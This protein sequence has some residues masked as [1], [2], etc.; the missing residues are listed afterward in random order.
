MKG[1]RFRL[2][3]EFSQECPETLERGM[4]GSA[5]RQIAAHPLKPDTRGL[6]MFGRRFQHVQAISNGSFDDMIDLVQNTSRYKSAAS[7]YN[8]GP[9]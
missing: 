7:H 9:Q 4:V 6:A 3:V 1:L 5:D 2:R 8:N